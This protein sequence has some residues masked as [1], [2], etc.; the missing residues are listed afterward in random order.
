MGTIANSY[1]SRI[2]KEDTVTHV[3]YLFFVHLVLRTLAF[4]PQGS[5][6]LPF[7][8]PP[9]AWDLRSQLLPLHPQGS[10]PN[11]PA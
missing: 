5:L 1:F 8:H 6:A 3:T 11:T 10:P 9:L 7:A 4:K 2:F